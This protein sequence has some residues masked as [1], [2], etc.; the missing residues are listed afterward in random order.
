MTPEAP[1][2]ALP[3]ARGP[4]AWETGSVLSSGS[5]VESWAWTQYMPPEVQVSQ[6]AELA[7]AWGDWEQ[8][9]SWNALAG[10]AA[11][12]VTTYAQQ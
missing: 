9:Q 12:L 5:T 8:L 10:S 7:Q 2:L 4:D 11:L 6:D 3:W 1:G